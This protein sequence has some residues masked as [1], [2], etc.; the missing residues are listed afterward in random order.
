[1]SGL[2]VKLALGD[3]VRQA[4]KAFEDYAVDRFPRALQFAL[5]GVAIDGVN[6][7][8]R[9]IPNIWHSPSKATRDAVRY[10]VDRDLLGRVASVGE[11]S[12]AVFVQDRQSVWLKYGL[13][14]RHADPPARR[15]RHRGVFRGPDQHQGPGQRQLLRTGLGSPGPTQAPCPGRPPD[16]GAGG[17]GVRPQHRR[18]DQGVGQL[19]RVRDQAGGLVPAAR[20]LHRTRHLRPSA[21]SRGRRRPQAAGQKDRRRQGLGPDDELQT[22]ATGPA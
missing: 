22:G 2:A 13:R 6:R 18:G 11:A 21:A 19:G 9:D 3:A 7:F 4:Q 14:R 5:T 12:A 16:R 10:V 15:C 8:R 1:M 17:R 20:L